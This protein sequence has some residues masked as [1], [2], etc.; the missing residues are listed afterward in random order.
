MIY[1]QRPILKNLSTSKLYKHAIKLKNMDVSSSGAL[2]AYSGNICGRSPK[3]KRIVMDENTQNIWWGPV[4]IPIDPKQYNSYKNESINYLETYNGNVYQIDA[5]A[6]WDEDNKIKLRLYTTNEYHALFFKDLLVHV[7]NKIGSSEEHYKDE[8]DSINDNSIFI[9]YDTSEVKLSDLKNIPKDN[10]LGDTIVGM[11]FTSMDMILYGTQ[12]AGEI[13]KG[14][15]TLMM[16]LMP[17]KN[18]LTL[19]SSANIKDDNLCLFFGLSGTGKTTLSANIDR[20]L[21][22]D[23]EHVWTDKGVFNV[24]GG[25]YAKCI[26]LDK[27]K[28]PEIYEAIKFGAVLEN[29]VHNEDFEVD[30][31]ADTITENTRCAYPL[32][33]IKNALIPATVSIHPQT[34]IFLMCDSFGLLPPVAK[35]T[36]DQAF[37]FFIAGYTSKIAGTEVGIKEPI[38]VFSACFGEPFLVWHPTRY[39]ELLKEKLNKY[40]PTVWILNTG[41]INGPYGVGKRISIKLTRTILNAIHNNEIKEFELFP[42]FNFEIPKEIKSGDELITSDVLNPQIK[43]QSNDYLEKLENLHKL[44]YKQIDSMKLK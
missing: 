6:G 44:F 21:I 35:L 16:Y 20:F 1:M 40:K 18:N 22:G 3:N 30:Y 11:N 17:I 7:T 42:I 28:E 33:H 15:L 14:I 4:N 34:I 26:K 37:D 31:D 29:V 32:N 27:N 9:I 13:K 10:N 2:L 24:E 25:C 38:P 41:W 39:G 12:Y 43:Y 36:Y 23:D 8:F 5:Y 19:H